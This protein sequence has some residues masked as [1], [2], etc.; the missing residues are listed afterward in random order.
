MM[1]LSNKFILQCTLTANLFFG[2]ITSVYH[3]YQH[4]TIPLKQNSSKNILSAKT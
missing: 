2:V 3:L 1:V 4:F